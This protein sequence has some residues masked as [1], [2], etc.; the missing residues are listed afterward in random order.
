MY[1]QLL[2]QTMLPVHDNFAV[3]NPKRNRACSLVGFAA[4]RAGGPER[5][6]ST[7]PRFPL[8]STLVHFHSG[9]RAREPRLLAVISSARRIFDAQTHFGAGDR[10]PDRSAVGI[11]ALVAKPS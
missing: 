8:G 10:E 7:L 2:P 5:T 3:L 1:R 4:K 6:F 9:H 11:R